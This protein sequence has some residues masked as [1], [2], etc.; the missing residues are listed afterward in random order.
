[1]GTLILGL[2]LGGSFIVLGRWIYSNPKTMYVSSLR[3]S[4][5]SPRVA[6]T[7]IFNVCDQRS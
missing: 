5:E 7:L 3:P 4:S 1:M 2:L 6:Q